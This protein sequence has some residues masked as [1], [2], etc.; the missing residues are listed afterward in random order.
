MFSTTETS[1]HVR[2]TNMT[3]YYVQGRSDGGISVYIPPKSVYHKKKLCGCSSPV[4]QDRFDTIY[5][6]VWG[7]NMF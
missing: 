1:V 3:L 6:H 4:T 2:D 5:V 7:I